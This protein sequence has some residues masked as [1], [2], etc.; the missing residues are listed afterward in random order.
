MSRSVARNALYSGIRTISFMVFPLVTYPYVTRVLMAQNLGKIDFATSFVSYFALVAALGI[1]T[2]ATRE[3]A[4]LRDDRDRLDEFASQIFTINMCS[5]LLAY[6]ALLLFV[7]L[8]PYLQGYLALLAIQSLTI[9]GTTMGVE[10]VFSLEE[11]YGYITARTILV[12]VVCAALMFA[13][14]RTPDDYVTYAAIVALSS[15]GGNVFNWFRARRYARVRLTWGFD[16][17]RHLLPML[18]LFGN[19]IAVSVY[20]NIDISLLSVMRGDYEVGIYGVSVKVYRLVKQLLVALVTVSLPRL[21]RFV[22]LG[23]A[24]A[25]RTLLERVA[26]GLLVLVAPALTLLFLM[27]DDV[28]LIIAGEGYLEAVPSLQVLCV[29]GLFAIAGNYFV[30]AVLLPFGNE[31][32]ALRS[33]VVGAV[34]NLLLNLAAIPLFGIVGAAA[35]TVAAEACVA[36]SAAWHARGDVD[37]RGLACDAAPA[38]VTAALGVVAMCAVHVALRG[39][40]MPW[41]AGFLVRGAALAGTYLLVT[42][43]RRDPLACGACNALAA[44]LGL[45]GNGHG[46]RKS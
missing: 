40:A 35:T 39:V 41:L 2:Y 10:W 33:S 8:W 45:G 32:F 9:L 30:N 43:A 5:T 14:V 26:H 16:A 29:A 31:A 22:T 15:V 46:G 17:R 42:L 23:D 37:L 20:V 7:L 12:Q 38:V 11:D 19:A 13:L 44:R 3:G 27:G 18:V 28:V 6:A 25:Y 21:S 1:N 24:Q 36:V 34:V 4:G